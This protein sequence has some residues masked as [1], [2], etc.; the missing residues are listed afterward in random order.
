MLIENLS[1][2]RG[3]SREYRFELTDENDNVMNLTGATVY[4]TVKEKNSDA[5]PGVFQLSSADPTQIDI[6][7]PGNG[8]ARIFVTNSNTQDLEI[9]SYIYD[10][11][12]QPAS[13]GV[14]TAVSG[15][16]T[17]SEDVTRTV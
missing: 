3:D 8:K 1:L 4:F 5:D 15:T 16:F 17:I 14:K 13:G 12:V 9:R 6:D 7:D 10:V 11:Q 2:P